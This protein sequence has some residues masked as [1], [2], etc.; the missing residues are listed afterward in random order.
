MPDLFDGSKATQEQPPQV[1]A[2]PKSTQDVLA[3]STDPNV[4]SEVM[5][6]E[7]PALSSLQAFAAK[8]P[9]MSF[10]SQSSTEQILLVLRRHPITQVPWIVLASVF[11]LLPIAMPLLP[12]L[13]GLPANYL[14]AMFVGWYLLVT[15]FVL[16]SFLSWFFN[17]YIITDER[18]IDVDFVSLIYKSVS[19]AKIDK[20]E[21]VTA[22]TGGALQAIFNYGS[23][24]IQTA[25]EKRE[26]DFADVPQPNKVTQLLNEL[27]LQEERE[28]FEGRVS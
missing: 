21:D 8:P 15:G 26:F 14:F 10:D 5:C 19:A 18:I 3:G 9:R 25:A 2:P 24:Y 1:K 16:E 27:I 22:R 23:V 20:F 7:K 6:K 4:Y 11:A 28:Q 17:V 13:N 12:I